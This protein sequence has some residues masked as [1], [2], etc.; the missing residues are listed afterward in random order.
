MISVSAGPA[1]VEGDGQH[2][3]AEAPSH[4]AL[5]QGDAGAQAKGF[6]LKVPGRTIDLFVLR[7]VWPRATGYVNRNSYR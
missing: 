1:G 3:E 6:P 7:S 2:L 4:V 5:L